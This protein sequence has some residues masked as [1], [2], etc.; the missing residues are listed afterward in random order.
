MVNEEQKLEACYNLMKYYTKKLN[1]C[2]TEY[3]RY[4]YLKRLSDLDIDIYDLECYLEENNPEFLNNN[5]EYIRIH[6]N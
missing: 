2:V 4:K 3:E 6:K 5:I 1:E